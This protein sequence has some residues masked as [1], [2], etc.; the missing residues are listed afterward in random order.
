MKAIFSYFNPNP[1]AKVDKKT[2]KPKKW[3]RCDCAIRAFCGALN[4]PWDIVFMDMC[5]IALKLHDMPDSPKVIDK[6]AQDNNMIKLSL[7]AYTSV[8]GFA[9]THN[10][11]YI[12]NI[13][14]HV[15]CIKDNQI[16]D[17]WNCGNYKLKTYYVKK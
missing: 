16:N 15:V 13:R 5:K 14:S 11:T 7:P 12:C 3:N 6:Y 2:G 8:S 9:M 10:G 1:D 17:V 4:L